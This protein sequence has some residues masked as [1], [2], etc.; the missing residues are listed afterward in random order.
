MNGRADF[1]ATPPLIIAVG[2]L[3]PK[4]G[5]GDLIRACNSLAQHGKLFQCEII[6]EGPLENELRAQIEEVRLNDRVLLPGAKP[7][8]Q[9]R[10]RLA[11]ANLFVLPSVIDSDGGMDNL[12]TVI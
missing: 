9:I 10:Q 5:F 8:R 2:R 7:Q 3:I 12:P 11:R 6:G 1:S 4:K